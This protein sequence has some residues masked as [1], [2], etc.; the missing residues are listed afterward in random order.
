MSRRR[1]A[2]A[3]LAACGALVA[4]PQVLPA[5]AAPVAQDGPVTTAR[6]GPP[7]G[8]AWL[9]GVITDQAGHPLQ[10]VNVEAWPVNP[11]ATEPVASDL[12]YENVADGQ[13][14]YFRLE[15][16]IHAR[17]VIVVSADTEDPYRTFRYNDGEPIRV[18]RRTTRKLG[19]SEIARV[20]RQPSKIAARLRSA[21]VK[22]GKAA[23]ITVTVTCK[24]VDPVLGKVTVAVAGKKVAGTLKEA[25]KG[26]ITLAL[27][28]LRKPG[29]YTVEVSY[30]GDS[31]VKKSDT[32]VTLTVKK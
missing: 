11:D 20:A 1:I 2:A 26:R 22:A 21:T 31:Y 29:K 6:G 24:N 7:V 19:T 23:P 13:R 25:S 28:G 5:S 15:V 17:Y 8:K 16:P 27:P 9:V 32:K 3:A 4:L 18:G 30:L 10:D 12:T 14:G